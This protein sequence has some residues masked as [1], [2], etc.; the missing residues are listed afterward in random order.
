MPQSQQGPQFK[1]QSFSHKCFPGL[2]KD[3]GS[4]T[5]YSP[6]K[7]FP[8]PPPQ[9]RFVF[10][11]KIFWKKLGLLFKLAVNLI[12][13]FFCCCCWCFSLNFLPIKLSLHSSLTLFIDIIT[14]KIW[15]VMS[16]TTIKKRR[17]SQTPLASLPTSHIGNHGNKQGWEKIILRISI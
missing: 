16:S 9:D 5:F 17:K 1:L 11:N 4:Q 12:K 3:A 7:I 10:T 8:E 6:W 13:R 15:W 14:Y 2:K